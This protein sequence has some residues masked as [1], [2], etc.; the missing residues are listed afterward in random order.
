MN[1]EEHISYQVGVFSP[2]FSDIYPGVELLGHMVVLSLYIY[3]FFFRKLHTVFHNGC[4]TL[5]YDKQGTRVPFYSHPP[6]YL[7]FVLFLVIAIMTNMTQ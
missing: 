3:N 1:I 6:Q 2:L 4:T 5:H 7:L